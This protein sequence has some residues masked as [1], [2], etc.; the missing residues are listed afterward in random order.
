MKGQTLTDNVVIIC[1]GAD[2]LSCPGK[3]ITGGQAV[4]ALGF[5]KK[6]I[7][8]NYNV[9]LITLA[10]VGYCGE[11]SSVATDKIKVINVH[12]A[13]SK[14]DARNLYKSRELIK[15]K[16]TAAINNVPVESSIVVSV[17]WMSGM[18]LLS[19]GVPRPLLWFHTA[20]SF[21]LQKTSPTNTL[22]TNKYL[23]KRHKTEHRVAHAVDFNWATNNYEFELIS[24]EL[25]VPM[26]KIVTIPRA[27]DH[28]EFKS[29]PY[30]QKLIDILFIGRIDERKGVYDIP[31]ILS[32]LPSKR[33]LNINIVGGT[34][35]EMFNYK[36]WFIKSFPILIENHEILFISAIPHRLISDLLNSAK[37]LLVPSHHETFANMVL[38]GMACKVSIV[39]TNV[40]G[41][42]ELLRLYSNA[43]TFKP[44]S[45]LQAA[46]GIERLLKASEDE[47]T[48][49]FE[50]PIRYTWQGTLQKF[51]QVVRRAC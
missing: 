1:A 31:H 32:K 49:G 26:N 40:G 47:V 35:L 37:L 15:S 45:Y 7:S 11:R 50:I 5:A 12:V 13:L 6:L 29:F 8:N 10:P 14:W 24:K 16:M 22:E 21:A 38:E 48:T 17:Y 33:K 23:Y 2:V 4:F 42:P 44:R 25:S 18:V 36:S 30:S 39:A 20:A 46:Y 19:K 51:E 28:E 3:A 43:T 27:I 34:S 9:W 41:V